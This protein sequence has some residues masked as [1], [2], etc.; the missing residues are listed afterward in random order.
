[1]FPWLGGIVCPRTYGATVT[2]KAAV[3]AAA[4][5]TATAPR[6]Q[7]RASEHPPTTPIAAVAAVTAYRNVEVRSSRNGYLCSADR[8]SISGHRPARATAVAGR[9]RRKGETTP[10]P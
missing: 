5:A 1:M 7:R 2:A 8:A 4:A 9:P 3:A 6:S 10:A